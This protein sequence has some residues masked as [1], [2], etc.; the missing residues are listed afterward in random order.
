MSNG[1]ETPKPERKKV[2]WRFRYLMIGF[3]TV[4]SVE[5]CA[6]TAPDDAKPVS[7]DDATVEA[8]ESSTDEAGDTLPAPSTDDSGVCAIPPPTATTTPEPCD[9]EK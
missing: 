2:Y 1:N 4:L 6:S 9:D 7:D 3:V 5:M 8:P